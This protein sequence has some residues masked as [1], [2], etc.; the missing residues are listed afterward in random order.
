M[1]GPPQASSSWL[2]SSH[3]MTEVPP[4]KQPLTDF[5][6]VRLQFLHPPEATSWAQTRFRAQNM[7][8]Q[9]AL[10][11]TFHEEE[12]LPFKSPK[13]NI[14]KIA[15]CNSYIFQN[16]HKDLSRPHIIFFFTLQTH[17]QTC[18]ARL[19]QISGSVLGTSEER[20]PRRPSTVTN[21]QYILKA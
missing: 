4:C 17:T 9:C 12:V 1:Q 20:V 10:R 7:P 3:Q 13:G 8:E 16:F 5:K 18:T 19:V 21:I 11:H 15:L 2:G 6:M 14:K